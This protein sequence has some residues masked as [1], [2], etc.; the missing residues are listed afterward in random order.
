MKTKEKKK[1][2]CHRH[3]GRNEKNDVRTEQDNEAK[4]QKRTHGWILAACE[5]KWGGRGRGR[6]V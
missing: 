2:T 5:P 6:W 4:K 3:G 1:E